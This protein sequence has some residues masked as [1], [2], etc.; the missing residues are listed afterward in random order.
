VTTCLSG[1]LGRGAQ[2]GRPFT[3]RLWEHAGEVCALNAQA[4]L[5]DLRQRDV[6]PE[7]NGD[8]LVADAP[9]GMAPEGL[10]AILVAY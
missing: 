5:D 7:A 2:W 4:V 8:R 1:I 3:G 10:K 6:T 9:A